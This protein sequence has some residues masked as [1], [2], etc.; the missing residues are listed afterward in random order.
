MRGRA[1]SLFLLAFCGHAWFASALGWNQS[2]R[3][4]A[5]LT[6][7]E[8]GP[9]RFML[10]IDEFVASDARNLMTGDWAL[11]ADGHFYSNKAPGVSLLGTPAYAVIY[12]AGRWLGVDVR[13][14]PATR[15]N[16]ILLN[17]WCSVA[18]TAAATIVLW[19]FLAARGSTPLEALLGA[20][21]FAFGTLVFPYDT[22][23][24]G[25]STVAACLLIAL[26]L[27]WWLRGTRRP[28]LAGAL[29]GV[30][31][32]IEYLALLPL[33]A[34]AAAFVTRRVRWRERIAF[35][36]APLLPLLVLL[37][38]QSAAF[39]DPLATTTS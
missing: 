5:I 1:A 4:A 31:V 26:C 18:W 12:G 20:L 24:W 21:A 32:S 3:V 16:T 38:Y 8:P 36:L 10:R 9:N 2:A 19:R 22:S 15:M 7:V 34:V 33:S 28:W 13:S 37:L 23:L 35:G 25:H 30:A 11:G 6:F 17:L 29:G 39:G 27:A 14:E